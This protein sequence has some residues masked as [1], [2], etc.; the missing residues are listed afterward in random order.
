MQNNPM[1]QEPN[2][3]NIVFVRKIT[4]LQACYLCPIIIINACT[5]LSSR[6]LFAKLE[7]NNIIADTSYLLKKKN[8]FMF[9]LEF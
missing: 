6:V 7:R 5:T 4:C 1:L 8:Y 3:Y 2:C 9:A